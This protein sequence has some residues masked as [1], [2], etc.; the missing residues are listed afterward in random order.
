MP[1]L[2]R[3]STDVGCL[4]PEVSTYEN[5]IGVCTDMYKIRK[6]ADYESVRRLYDE[7]DVVVKVLAHRIVDGGVLRAR[8][9]RSFAHEKGGRVHFLKHWADSVVL[10]A[11]LDTH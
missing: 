9:R 1:L 4:E 6:L 5:E 2:S 8:A 10:S 11:H 7:Q 3:E